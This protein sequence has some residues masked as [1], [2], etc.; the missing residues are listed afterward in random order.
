MD[1]TLLEK[2]DSDAALEKHLEKEYGLDPYEIRKAKRNIEKYAEE[3]PDAPLGRVAFGPERRP[4]VYEPNTKVEKALFNSLYDH[5]DGSSKLNKQ[6]ADLI[7][8]LMRRGSYPSILIP[9]TVPPIYRGMDVS[10]AWLAKAL[11]AEARDLRY[12]GAL[13]LKG[14][15][16]VNFT[17]VPRRGASSWTKSRSVAK[18][19]HSS[20]YNR[21]NI[22]LHAD[23]AENAGRL[24]DARG[25]YKNIDLLD[26]FSDEKEI[27]GI[28][29][30]RVHMIEWEIDEL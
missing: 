25:M 4:P 23:V 2:V 29:P 19:F 10:K 13:G 26:R 15:A 1:H 12:K 9:P 11:G 16:E 14:K 5:F 6:S 27:L 24:L 8:R 22:T 18:G 20:E 28:G 17:F 3:P 30:I 7:I 21:A